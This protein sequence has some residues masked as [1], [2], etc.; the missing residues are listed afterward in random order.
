[1]CAPVCSRQPAAVSGRPYCE[2]PDAPASSRPALPALSARLAARCVHCAAAARAA[3]RWCTPERPSCR[4]WGSA[5]FRAVFARIAWSSACC[6][7]G[8]KRWWTA[9]W[10]SCCACCGSRS[11]RATGDTGVRRRRPGAGRD[12]AAGWGPAAGCWAGRPTAV[13]TSDMSAVSRRFI[14]DEK[15]LSYMGRCT[16]Q[17]HRDHA[18]V[19]TANPTRRSPATAQQPSVLVFRPH[20]PA[21]SIVVT[22][23][24]S[25]PVEFGDHSH[26]PVPFAIA[27]LRHVVSSPPP[28]LQHSH[29]CGPG[30]Q[31]LPA[32]GCTRVGRSWRSDPGSAP[33][34]P[35][36]VSGCHACCCTV[37]PTHVAA[38]HALQV[39]ALGGDAAVDGIPLGPIPHPEETPAASAAQQAAAPAAAAYRA[40]GV[41]GAA[42]PT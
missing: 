7:R 24:H 1:M 21:C 25:T 37:S 38:T 20:A 19:A 13:T 42:E 22:G 32:L 8:T 27:H 18:V 33:Q 29:A 23:D 36:A 40:A 28:L 35:T 9:W 5:G 30:L 11:G 31:C 34:A 4:L 2:V 10:G 26:E 16:G 15:R 17:Q 41:A 39:Q 12:A 6:S 3:R 14:I